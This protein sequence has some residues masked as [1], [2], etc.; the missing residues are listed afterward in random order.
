MSHISL[1]AL[2]KKLAARSTCELLRTY[3]D[4]QLAS[5]Q[6]DFDSHSAADGRTLVDTLVDLSPKLSAVKNLVRC[7]NPS[8][9]DSEA[10]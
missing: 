4:E 5:A 8:Q 6:V 9:R 2:E 10:R 1:V 7:L 3:M